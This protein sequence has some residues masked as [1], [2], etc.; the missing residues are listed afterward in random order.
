MDTIQLNN[1]Y[2]NNPNIKWYNLT[3]AYDIPIDC[4]LKYKDSFNLIST[5]LSTSSYAKIE[6]KFRIEIEKETELPDNAMVIID[7]HYFLVL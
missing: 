7:I 2:S 3:N 5:P 4:S 1:D 6:V